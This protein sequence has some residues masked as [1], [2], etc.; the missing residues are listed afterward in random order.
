MFGTAAVSFVS[1]CRERLYQVVGFLSWTTMVLHSPAQAGNET[2]VT[3]CL[4]LNMKMLMVL[5]ENCSG[6]NSTHRD[7]FSSNAGQSVTFLFTA[8]LCRSRG[9]RQ[10]SFSTAPC[11]QS[12]CI[13][14]FISSLRLFHF[15][16][17]TSCQDAGSGPGPVHVP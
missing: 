17:V 10:C 1:L 12:P 6:C 7:M 15:I 3:L 9:C 4:K 11:S 16:C 2:T 13:N 8:N 5:I 14:I